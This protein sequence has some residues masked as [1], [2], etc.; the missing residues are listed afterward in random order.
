MGEPAVSASETTDS[1]LMARVR[2][3]ELERLADLFERHQKRLFNF[4]LRLTGQRGQAEDLVQEVFVRILKY[5]ESFKTEA[6]FTPWMFA[7]ARNTA[8]D[9]YR[10]RPRE[11]PEN[12]AAP[13]PAAPLEHPIERLERRE[14]SELLGRALARLAPEKR[15]LLLLARF[16]E[17]RYETIGELLGVSVGA[18]KVRVHRALKDLRAAYQMVSEEGLT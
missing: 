4:F 13:E 11:V 12:P 8:V 5:R 16:G 17:M 9:Q 2:D 15:E 1:E 3:G 18:I 6:E 14:Q 7:L 10:K